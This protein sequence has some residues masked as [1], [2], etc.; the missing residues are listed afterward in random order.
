MLSRVEFFLGKL[1]G[2]SIFF[3]NMYVFVSRFNFFKAGSKWLEFHPVRS[4]CSHTTEKVSGLLVICSGAR[5]RSLYTFFPSYRYWYGHFVSGGVFG[6]GFF[7]CCEANI[8][9]D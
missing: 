7:K 5:L 4:G 9:F 2:T 1:R 6:A 3:K 8:R